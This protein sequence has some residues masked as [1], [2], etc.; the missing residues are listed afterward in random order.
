MLVVDSIGITIG[1]VE[2][3]R[4]EK[5]QLADVVRCGGSPALKRSGFLAVAPL[6]H[7]LD[8]EG[9]GITH[10]EVRHSVGSLEEVAGVE[11][12]VADLVSLNVALEQVASRLVGN[13]VVIS[14]GSVLSVV[15]VVLPEDSDRPISSDTASTNGLMRGN[16]LGLA[17]KRLGHW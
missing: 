15:E 7:S 2:R 3:N 4:S 16:T 10:M 6:V 9:V 17:N 13:N 5:L 11:V 8:S 14:W 12:V 1:P